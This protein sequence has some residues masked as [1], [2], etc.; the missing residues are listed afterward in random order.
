MTT[1]D[2]NLPAPPPE[3]GPEPE[4]A[5]RADRLRCE[6][7]H[8]QL[9]PT[10]DVF[11]LSKQAKDWLHAAEERDELRARLNEETQQHET[12]RGELTTA[13]AELARLQNPEKKRFWDR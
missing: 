2:P 12:T 1:I 5:P 11:R 13:R 9:T 8:C 3:P 10:G 4:P 7:C 6:N